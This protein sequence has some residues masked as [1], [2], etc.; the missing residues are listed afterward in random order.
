[1]T[2]NCSPSSVLSKNGVTI[3]RV[4]L[5]QSRFYPIIRILKYSKKPTNFPVAKPV[6]PPISPVSTLRS[7]MSWVLKWGN[8]M[9]SHDDQTMTLAIWTRKIVSSSL[10]PYSPAPRPRSFL[11]IKTRNNESRIA[12]PSMPKLITYSAL[13]KPR[14]P[15]PNSATTTV[16]EKSLM[17]L[18]STTKKYMSRMT[19]TSDEMLPPSVTTR[20]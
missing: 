20:L 9:P 6:G 7:L 5:I 14:T 8:L 11:Q 19:P 10:T 15:L 2:E 4:L 16:Y 18:S 13:S 17:D 1:M 12:K 3:S